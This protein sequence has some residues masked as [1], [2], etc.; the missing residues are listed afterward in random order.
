LDK[1][2]VQ[3]KISEDLDSHLDHIKVRFSSLGNIK[4][5]QFSI[6]EKRLMNEIFDNLDDTLLS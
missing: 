4:K 2:D 6:E 5:E 1:E 3:K